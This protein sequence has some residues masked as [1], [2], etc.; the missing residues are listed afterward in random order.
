M[1]SDG[2]SLRVGQHRGEH[3]RGVLPSLEAPVLLDNR[4]QPMHRGMVHRVLQ[5]VVVSKEFFSIML[6][7]WHKSNISQHPHA[8]GIRQRT[9]CFPSRLTPGG[10]ELHDPMRQNKNI[11]THVLCERVGCRDTEGMVST[12]GPAR[13]E[14]LVPK[15]VTYFEAI[16]LSD[17]VSDRRNLTTT[18]HRTCGRIRSDKCS[19]GFH[20]KIKR[21][22]PR[23]SHQ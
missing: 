15:A 21:R 4:L 22:T 9:N 12:E 17:S 16:L 19:K 7:Y 14:I 20:S 11:R 1:A 13:C 6:I 3:H 10:P 5:D 2:T 23:S 8:I 18:A